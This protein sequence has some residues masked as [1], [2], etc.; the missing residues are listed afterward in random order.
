M[1]Y[2]KENIKD[3]KKDLSKL[4]SFQTWLNTD[5]Y[6]N[7]QMKDALQFMKELADRDGMKS[8]IDENGY[9]GYIEIGSGEEMVG[10]LT[11]IDVVPPG[12][13]SEWLSDP[14]TLDERDGKYYGRGTS[15]DKGPLMLLYYLMLELKDQK[16]NRRVRLIFPT[17]EESKWRGVSKYNELEEKPTFGI[18]PD[19][20]FPV[21]FLE[22]EILHCELYSKG[23][24]GWTLQG[25]TALNVVPSEAYYTINGKTTTVKGV[26]AHAMQPQM[27]DNAVTKAII[28]LVEEKDHPLIK[29]VNEQIKR[30]VHGETIFNGL[31]EDDY[32]KMTLNLGIADFNK[33]FSKISLD[34]RIPIT[35]NIDKVEAMYKE[36]AKKYGL[37]YKYTKKDKL[38]YI[39]KDNWIIQDLIQAYKQITGEL[40]EPVATGGGTYAKAI[41]NVVAYGP[42][43]PTSP[44][45]FHQYNEHIIIDH[46]IQAYD[47]YKK[48]F[49]KWTK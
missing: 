8:Y 4:I 30:E 33:D 2:L 10:I 42:L 26:S 16:L 28:D 12:K 17:D 18:T 43:L 20:M 15:D 29:F 45:T 38:V 25:G 44:M 11:H 14:F 34:H 22:R 40:L 27:G 21:V 47:I 5:E 24:N 9:Y 46:Y 1:N 39:P 13:V 32:A 7:Q 35:S 36:H 3:Y 37:E 48:V 19:A 31:I 23:T 49:E 41:K 6:P